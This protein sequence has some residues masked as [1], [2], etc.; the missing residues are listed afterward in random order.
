MQSLAFA[1]L[2]DAPSLKP[3]DRG[4]G[5]DLLEVS[6]LWLRRIVVDALWLDVVI[7]VE[8]GSV[9]RYHRGPGIL[10][11]RAG[12]A[13]HA[14]AALA[15][16]PPLVLILNSVCWRLVSNGWM[17]PDGTTGC[18]LADKNYMSGCLASLLS[19]ARWIAASSRENAL[20]PGKMNEFGFHPPL[21]LCLVKSPRADCSKKKN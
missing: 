3:G 20:A 18:R 9:T 4:G 1:F 10:E 15:P 19:D 5:R 11:I 13:C 14:T 21:L 8:I 16:P 7:V 6:P 2:L 17:A 12:L